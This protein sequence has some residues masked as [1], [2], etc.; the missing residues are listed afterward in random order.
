MWAAHCTYRPNP[1]TLQQKHGEPIIAIIVFWHQYFCSPAVKRITRRLYTSEIVYIPGRLVQWQIL[2]HTPHYN[3]AGKLIIYSFR[4]PN[5]TQPN[6]WPARGEFIRQSFGGL[7]CQKNCFIT[8]LMILIIRLL[9][10]FNFLTCSFFVTHS[11][12]S[13]FLST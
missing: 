8:K 13:T 6:P 5:K 3:L 2:G 7:S 9:L 12:Y 4:T 1:T 11:Q 10:P